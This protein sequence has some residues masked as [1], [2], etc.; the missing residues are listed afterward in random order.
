MSLDSVRKFADVI[1]RKAVPVHVLINNGE[2]VTT[3]IWEFG[4]K[5]SELK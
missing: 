2:P 5:C 4:K 1:I 3:K